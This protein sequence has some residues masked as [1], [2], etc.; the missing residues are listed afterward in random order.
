MLLI[1]SA[2]GVATVLWGIFFANPDITV[3]HYDAGP[4]ED[5]E[6]RQ[7]N[8]F[9][10]IDLY[11]YGLDNGIVRALD[12]RVESSGCSV[13]WLPGD[14]RGLARN[15]GSLPGAFEDP[16]S[17]A[18]WSVEGNAISGTSE[19]LRTPQVTFVPNADGKLHVRVE[20]I[21]HPLG[22]R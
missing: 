5:F 6:I 19:P 7:V 4:I 18:V 2:V 9:P 1:V 21:N 17:G 15:P 8:A 20:L 16:C 13:R 10:E 12:G 14:R 3:V 22:Q 11:I